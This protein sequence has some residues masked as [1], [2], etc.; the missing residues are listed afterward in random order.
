[1]TRAPPRT[2]VEDPGWNPT[3]VGMPWV[4]S[5]AC[6][7]ER[8]LLTQA[9]R[10]LSL[11]A[12]LAQV[13]TV[14]AMAAAAQQVLSASDLLQPLPVVAMVNRC[15]AGRMTGLAVPFRSQNTASRAC[16]WH[17]ISR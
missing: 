13:V 15:R 1:M 11:Q 7:V 8:D 17:L 4:R 14:M 3:W 6:S 16:F 9:I 10:S 2:M 12:K 5:F